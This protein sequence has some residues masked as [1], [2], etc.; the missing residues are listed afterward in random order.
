MA[1]ILGLPKL[2]PTM[3]EGTLVRWAKK[4][5]DVVAVDDL[6]AEVETDKA[7]MEFRSFD[8][9]TLLK[10]LVPE[11]T[12]LAPEE[13]V[14]IVGNQGDDISALLSSA[15]TSAPSTTAP[16]KEPVPKAATSSVSP[17]APTAPPSP[18]SPTRSPSP[19]QANPAEP[20]A[21]LS[22]SQRVLASPVVRK[23]A[24]E[25][26]IDLS[27][28]FG[29]GPHGRIVKRDL[30]GGG[31]AQPL[32]ARRAQ[33]VPQEDRVVQLS[34]MRK[35]I[36]R[37]LVESKQQVP[38]FYLTLDVDVERLAQAREELNSEL[39]A[40]G[41]KL[42]FNDFVVKAAALALRKVPEANASFEGTQIRYFGRVDVSVAVAVP[43]GLVT[44]VLR[45]AD[46]KTLPELSTEMRELAQRARNKK[47]MP[48]EMMGGTFSVSNL[49]MYGIEEFAAVI[50]PPEGAILAVGVIRQEPVVKNG[51]LSIGQR[52][53]LTLSCDHRVVDGAVG[54]QLLSALRTYLEKPTLLCI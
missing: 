10:I 33:S 21:T 8:N 52:M 12:T 23:L 42:S 46:Q 47:L 36:A 15:T 51:E 2:S 35:T 30:E 29:S 50:N 11:G 13:P 27:A 44:P 22:T 41:V 20:V 45:N 48:E 49:G 19:A 38:H 25:Q 6:L 7:T 34:S 31:A 53:K 54:A 26:N 18:P 17:T 16:A 40:E 3:E 43:D 9:T 24:R 1:K 4:E 28:V 14:A 37:R 32:F 39:E 5:G